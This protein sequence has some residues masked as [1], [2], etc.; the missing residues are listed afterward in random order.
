[1]MRAV[2]ASTCIALTALAGCGGGSTTTADTSATTTGAGPPKLIKIDVP[3]RYMA[4]KQIVAHS[5]CLACH[6]I[7]RSG[8]RNLAADLT[9]VGSRLSRAAI[10]RSL[11]QGP[12]I[13][14]SYRSLGEQKLREIADFLASLR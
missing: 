14:P 9:N 3:Q 13:M 5:A 4:A 7:G 6:Q 8:N 12:A 1:M 10:L 2:A 11:E